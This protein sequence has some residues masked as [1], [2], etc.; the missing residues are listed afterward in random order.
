[1][2][3]LLEQTCDFLENT[4]LWWDT[5]CISSQVRQYGPFY[6]IVVRRFSQFYWRY[7]H[8]LK[9]LMGWEPYFTTAV[10]SSPS[11]AADCS[12][13]RAE[14]EPSFFFWHIVCKQTQQR[15]F[16]FLLSDHVL[17]LPL[18]FYITVWKQK[19]HIGSIVSMRSTQT[20]RC[21]CKNEPLNFHASMTQ[22]VVANLRLLDTEISHLN[23]K[24]H[25]QKQRNMQHRRWNFKL[26]LQDC[27]S[28]RRSGETLGDRWKLSHL[29][30]KSVSMVAAFLN[31][32]LYFCRLRY[33][34][35]WLWGVLGFFY[36]IQKKRTEPKW[37]KSE[38]NRD[39]Y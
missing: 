17:L 18:C 13:K 28:C 26:A 19:H 37:E 21:L 29:R 24:Q 22:K 32:S 20:F 30:I 33:F 35:S 7:A 4:N 10:L 27:S 34:T 25:W 15:Y 39:S 16:W 6:L 9:P 31:R 2:C 11:Y 36:C 1:M 14:K 12:I 23:W 8:L 3:L 5:Y 38:R